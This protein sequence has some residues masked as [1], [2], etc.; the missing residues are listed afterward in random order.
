MATVIDIEEL[1]D[2]SL[3]SENVWTGTKVFDVLMNAVNK[4]IEGQYNLQRLTG[5]DYATVY[6]GA[7]QMVITQSMGF[8][9][10]QAEKEATVDNLIKQA[11]V[12]QAQ[13]DLYKRQKEGFDDDAK[14]KLL[15]VVMDSWS[16]A[17]S[18]SPEGVAIPDAITKQ[19]LDKITENAMVALGIEA[20]NNMSASNPIDGV[21]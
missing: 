14:Q 21:Y 3:N 4:N 1:T 9:M 17:Y 5:S 2:G 13:I 20:V 10:G 16:V 12:Y 19:N 8:L 7:L 18:T 6:L 15:K 11:S